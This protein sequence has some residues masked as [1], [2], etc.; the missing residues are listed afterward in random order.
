MFTTSHR[1]TARLLR[2]PRCLPAWSHVHNQPS[3]RRATSLAT[4][5]LASVE[6]CSQPAFLSR[7]A[8][9]S[10]NTAPR[11]QAA[12]WRGSRFRDISGLEHRST[13]ASSVVAR[14][15]ISWTSLVLNTAPR[16]QAA[17][18]RGSRFRDISGLEHRSTLASSVV[19]TQPISWTSL[20]LNTAPRWQAAWWRGSR[21]LR[22]RLWCW[23][24]VSTSVATGLGGGLAPFERQRSPRQNS[25]HIPREDPQSTRDRYFS[26]DAHLTSNTFST[27]RPETHSWTRIRHWPGVA[28]RGKRRGMI[29]WPS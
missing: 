7:T 15:P 27:S 6:P 17:W 14:Q 24:V 5:L 3:P 8:S 18:W 16:W 9:S 10:L 28:V 2:P 4:T 25:H 12:W 11:W 20:V 13:L 26:N 19:A 29:R 23:E 1:P 22:G 21:I